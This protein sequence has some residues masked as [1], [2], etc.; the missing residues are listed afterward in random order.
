MTNCSVCGTPLEHMDEPCPNCLPRMAW[1]PPT[2]R[3]AVVRV[4]HEPTY[5][6][7]C[8]ICGT[9]WTIDDVPDLGFEVVV[10]DGLQKTRFQCPD[11]R[12]VVKEE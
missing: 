12:V 2:Q 8:P 1:R 4:Y 9:Y 11:C 5:W 6:L 7:V 10:V 3:V